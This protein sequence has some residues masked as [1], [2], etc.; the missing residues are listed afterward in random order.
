MLCWGTMGV[1]GV[2]LGL[3]GSVGHWERMLMLLSQPQADT[4]HI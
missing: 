3:G 2:V 4:R 1:I